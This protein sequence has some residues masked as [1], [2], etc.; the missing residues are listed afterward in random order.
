MSGKSYVGL[1]VIVSVGVIVGVSVSVGV[2][3]TVGVR[4]SVGVVVRVAVLLEVGVSV[5]DGDGV[6]VGVTVG[7]LLAVGVGDANSAN[8]VPQAVLKNAITNRVGTSQ[9]RTRS[10]IPGII[11]TN[12][13]HRPLDTLQLTYGILYQEEMVP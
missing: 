7:V 3:V 10:R 13:Q 1:G 9:C 5:A 8:G 6:C 4:V 12:S 2:R 11:T